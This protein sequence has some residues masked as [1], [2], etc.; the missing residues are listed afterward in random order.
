MVCSLLYSLSLTVYFLLLVVKFNMS[1]AKIK[2]K[3][4]P[5]LHAVPIIYSL[6]VSSSIYATNNYNSSG[7]F[8]WIAP[9][10][11]NCENDPKVE[12]Q[13]SGNSHVFIWLGAGGPLF[14]ALYGNCTTLALIWWTYRSQVR[15]NQA[16]G[17][18]FT[19][20]SPSPRQQTDEEEQQTEESKSKRSCCSFCPIKQCPIN[21]NC[22]TSQ[23]TSVLA[24]YLSR[25]S[26]AAIRNSEEICNRAAAYVIGFMLTNVFSFVNRY[27]EMYGSG[28]V[29]FIII[30]LP[31]F[32]FPL[33]G[34]FNVI[35]Y[36]YP[37]VISY[38]RI[39]T[40]CNWFQAF[41][42]VINSGGD[43]DQSRSG[44]ATR[45]RSSLRQ[46]QRVLEQSEYTQRSRGGGNMASISTNERRE[47]NSIE[48][49]RLNLNTTRL[50][51][52]GVLADGHLGIGG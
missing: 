46:M 47:I 19:Q 9:Q 13:S 11:L 40:D 32:F 52:N 1:E 3:F 50:T 45:R 8:C 27:V 2:K 25:P 22:S 16:Y 43:S 35:V 30:F 31:R 49:V 39:H 36:T 15:R 17:N 24:N 29:P 44:R 6:T 26:R 28:P 4:E 51:N 18:V 23:S 7:F 21:K 10:P 33:Q 5:F 38:R 42:K 20:S 34:L 37:Y 14:T 48:S 12:C 41:W